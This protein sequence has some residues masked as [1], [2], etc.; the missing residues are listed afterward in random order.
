MVVKPETRK[1]SLM[2]ISDG[3]MDGWMMDDR[4]MDESMD[5]WLIK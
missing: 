4:G 5:G 2:P 3:W 1:T